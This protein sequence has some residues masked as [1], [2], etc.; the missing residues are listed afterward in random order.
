MTLTD[1][2]R[3]AV[4]LGELWACERALVFIDDQAAVIERVRVVCQQGAETYARN[5]DVAATY[6]EILADL[7]GTEALAAAP[8]RTAPDHSQDEETLGS[9]LDSYQV[10]FRKLAAAN[11]R[12]ATATELLKRWRKRKRSHW[13]IANDTDAFLASAAP[14]QSEMTE[15]QYY[16]Y[17]SEQD[18]AADLGAAA[19]ARSDATEQAQATAAQF[20][21]NLLRQ[22][23]EA[24][25]EAAA[26]RAQL[27]QAESMAAEWQQ[28]ANEYR[29]S[30][31][32]ER[33][34]R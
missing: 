3:Q 7:S 14:A 1:I 17:G 33:D 5:P 11:A 28:T 9:H 23:T 2:E 13:A 15:E 24:E 26:L 19:N 10:V 29:I 6:R 31:Q 18:T 34:R 12:V 4:S 21:Q 8:E 16:S 20:N 22:R 27:A 25:S 30:Y 32:A